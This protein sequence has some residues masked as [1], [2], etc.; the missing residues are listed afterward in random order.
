MTGDQI[1]REGKKPIILQPRDEVIMAFVAEFRL[2][3]RPQLQDLLDF[4]CVTRINIRLKKLYNH[5]FLDRRFLPTIMGNP[6]AL[7]FLGPNGV[8]NVAQNSGIDPTRLE[9]DRRHIH[10]RKD[11]FLNHHLFLNE[12]RIAFALAIREH[13]AMSLERWIK[14]KDCLLEFPTIQG[15]ATTLRPDGGLI[16][17][18][19]ARLYS[20]FVEVDCST[21][22][23]GRLRAKAKAYLNYAQ[24]GYS[25]QDFG[26]Q[27]F[28]VLIITKTEERLNNLKATIEELTDRLFYFST[29]D[30]ILSGSVVDR[31]WHRAGRRG[32]FHLL[33]D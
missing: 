24:S 30:Q 20:F 14:E 28:R 9:K 23:N 8:I 3:S 12:V 4:P 19:Q 1:A 21:M 26:F 33:E 15:R 10:D 25:L 31:L 32:L 16:L 17:S 5:G 29:R 18:Y 22:S 27:Y 2:L 6:Q 11:L 7:Y 13:R